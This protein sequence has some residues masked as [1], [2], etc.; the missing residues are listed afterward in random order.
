MPAVSPHAIG[1]CRNFPYEVKAARKR[2]APGR[3]YPGGAHASGR[4][5]RSPAS[6]TDDG[7]GTSMHGSTKP[8]HELPKVSA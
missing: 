1:M 4:A 3:T 7:T 8:Q 6:T 5:A 2:A